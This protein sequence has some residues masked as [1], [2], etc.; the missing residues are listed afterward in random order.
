MKVTVYENKFSHSKIEG[1]SRIMENST[2]YSVE[3]FTGTRYSNYYREVF[4][5]AGDIF[6]TFTNI[7]INI[8]KKGFNLNTVSEKPTKV[9]AHFVSL[10][11]Q[12]SPYEEAMYIIESNEEIL[13]VTDY[14]DFFSITCED[15]E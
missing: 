9:Q 12:T 6:I 4:L 8:D 14:G 5:D 10:R 1:S 15:K 11:T 2:G 3:L 7:S 13:T